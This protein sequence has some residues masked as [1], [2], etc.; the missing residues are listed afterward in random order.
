M[1]DEMKD[2]INRLATDESYYED[3]FRLVKRG[4]LVAFSFNQARVLLDLPDFEKRLHGLLYS[5]NVA[6]FNH[7]TNEGTY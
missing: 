5:L 7:Y 6:P 2:F 4:Q 3:C 1:K